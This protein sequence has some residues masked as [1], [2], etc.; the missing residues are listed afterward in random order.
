MQDKF[1]L[2]TKLPEAIQNEACQALSTSDLVTLS[3]IAKRPLT[4]FTAVIDIRKILHHVVRG[5][6]EE[7]QFII[8]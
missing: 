1:D 4:L 8:K 7:V 5:N 3:T 6:H 2:F